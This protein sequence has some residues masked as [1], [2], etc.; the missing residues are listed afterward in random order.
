MKTAL[1]LL[2]LVSGAAAFAP[3]SSS[4]TMS[5]S[6]QMSDAAAPVEP[7]PE[8]PQ[9]EPE[10]PMLEVKT[11]V[12]CFGAAPLFGGP[13][14]FGENYWDK[15]TTEYGSA[16]TGKYIRAAELKHGRAA[17]VATV[18]YAFHKLGFTFDNI[19]VHEYLSPT[20]GVKFADLAAMTPLEAMKNVPG[21][22]LA[23][24]FAACALVEIFELTHADGE[25]KTDESVAPGLRPGGLTGDLGWNPLQINITDRRRLSEIQNGRAAMF[26]ICAWIAADSIPGSFPLYLP[27]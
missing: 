7:T 23:Q 13:V 11:K 18:G 24:M 5:T 12:P 21:E 3:S 10:V 15:I 4:N 17:M 8:A 27:W 2:G 25:I 16:E 22:G 6:L 14:F 20:Q 1:T 19:S 9:E 26:A